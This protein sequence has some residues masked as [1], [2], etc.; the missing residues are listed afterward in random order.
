MSMV[1]VQGVFSVKP[2]DRDRFLESSA[3]GIRAS[4]EEEG[5]LEYV[6]AADPADPGRVVLSERWES[7]EHLQQHLA[8]LSAARSSSDSQPAARPA[9][10]S[11]EITIFDVAGSRR[12]G[13]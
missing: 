13:G 11:Q 10:L 2:E 12:L 5:C 9:P 7:A 1:I 6:M 4:R 3:A 8:N